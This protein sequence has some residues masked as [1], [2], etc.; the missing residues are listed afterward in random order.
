MFVAQLRS[1]LWTIF[2]NLYPAYLRMVYK[3]PLGGGV[4]I[5]RK[6]YL[7]LSINPKGIHLGDRVLITSCVHILAHD[8]STS[9]KLDTYIGDDSFVGIGAI[10]LP[11][12]RIGKEVIIGAG[13][14]VTKD[15]PDHCIAV[16]NPAKVIKTGIRMHGGQIIN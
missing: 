6:A 16:G 3:M 11:G 12:V 1:K 5:S 8:Y 13:S 7:D 2:T 14:V 9:K 15:I 10:I 4:R